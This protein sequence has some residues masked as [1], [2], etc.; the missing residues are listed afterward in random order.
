MALRAPSLGWLLL[1]AAAVTWAQGTLDL[2]VPSTREPAR[3]SS[4]ACRVC[5]EIRSIREVASEAPAPVAPQNPAHATSVSGNDWA[6]V[7]AAVYTPI[8]RGTQT[9]WQMGAVGTQEMAQRLG[10]STYEIEV[11]MDDGERRLV[12]RRDA[13]RFQI[14]QRVTLS[15]GLMEP[16]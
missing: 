2:R 6:V 8:G 14:G 5:G 4:S 9:D 12:R 15:E 3:A 10:S 11:R 1:G 16:L 7:G 13:T